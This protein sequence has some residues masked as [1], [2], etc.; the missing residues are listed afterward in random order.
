M[1]DGRIKYVQEY[2]KTFYDNAEKPMYSIGAVQDISEQVKME[3]TLR[4]TQKMDALGKLTGGIAHDF[5]NML[6]VIMGYSNLLEGALGEQPQLAKYAHEIHHAGER[7]AKLTKKLLAFSRKKNPDAKSVDLNALL[8]DLHNMLQ[9]TLTARI[10]LLLD[11]EDD[12]WPVW[13]DDGELED[14]IINI[15]INAMHATK[16]NGKFTLRTRNEQ[17]SEID[18]QGINLNPGD[19]VLLSL[20]DTGSGIDETIKERIFEPF[21]ST[22]GE[23]GTGLGLSQVYGFVESSKGTIKVYSEAGK[24]TQLMLYFPRYMEINSDKQQ[25]EEKKPTV[26]NGN[27]TILVVDDEVALLNLTAEILETHGYQVIKA[28]NGKRA[29]EILGSEK[30]DLLFS[31]VI[32]PEM[33]GY[34]LAVIVQKKYP[35]VKIQLASGF[36]DTRHKEL[37]DTSLH[38]KLLS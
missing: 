12:L 30:I 29:L 35:D 25:L 31:D 34:Q 26:L 21:F 24:G 5:N 3:E 18:A 27:E 17:I 36:A 23:K 19:Y 13:V 20:T 16:G 15:S 33:D 37:V 9:K 10:K 11:T 38:Q 4:R 6:G 7:G 1:T 22:K 8:H 28:E 32:M 14:A 2:S